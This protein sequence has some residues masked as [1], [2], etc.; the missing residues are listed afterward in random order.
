MLACALPDEARLP[1]PPLALARGQQPAQPRP[2]NPA[3]TAPPQL[4]VS[5][6]TT[7]SGMLLSGRPWVLELVHFNLETGAAARAPPQ[8][9]D[10]VADV[11]AFS[12]GQ[13]RGAPT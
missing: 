13:A 9:W 7:I 2:R 1:P 4:W 12:P 6:A 8:L 5:L 3:R 11:L 10:G